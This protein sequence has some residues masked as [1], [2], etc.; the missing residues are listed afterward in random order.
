[1]VN[2]S[3][4][5]RRRCVA[6]QDW[7]FTNPGVLSVWAVDGDGRMYLV[8]EVYRSQKVIG[9]WVDQAVMAHRHFQL[10]AIAC[11]PSEPGFI[12]DYQNAGLPAV[13]AIN[14]ISPG[15]QA[16]MARLAPAGDGRPRLYVY[17]GAIA[18]RDEIL[19]AINKPTS[20]AEEFD[21]YVWPKGIDGRTIKEVPADVN[22][23]G[24]DAM[25]YACA[26]VDFGGLA[27]LGVIEDPW[28]DVRW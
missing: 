26:Y 5:L 24:M 22:N 13:K 8:H 18:E 7:G 25:R 6:G 10:E 21:S 23:H 14:D 1:M 2:L 17:Q 12:S 28:A 4:S 11:N 16:V 3:E 15:I 9:W 27:E 19:A 20:T